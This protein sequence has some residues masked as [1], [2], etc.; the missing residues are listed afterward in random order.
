[1]S[2]RQPIFD[3]LQFAQHP[4]EASVAAIQRRAEP[5][6]CIKQFARSMT[7]LV[8]GLFQ[9]R[10]WRTPLE[11][12]NRFAERAL[13]QTPDSTDYTHIDALSSK[14]WDTP[15]VVADA[16]EGKSG[17]ENAISN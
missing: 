17:D 11:I 5:S 13:E 7:F 6:Q 2:N 9:D 14:L 3:R 12:A 10:F 16:D 15:G 4:F 1:M 8:S